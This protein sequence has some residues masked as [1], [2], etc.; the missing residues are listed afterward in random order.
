M[1]LCA[2][3]RSGALRCANTRTQAR[4]HALAGT[5]T[6]TFASKRCKQ[7]SA[8]ARTLV[9]VVDS[10]AQVSLDVVALC[11][12]CVCLCA[13]E[14]RLCVSKHTFASR[15][16]SPASAQVINLDPSA[17]RWLSHGL[18]RRRRRRRRP[19]KRASQRAIAGN[20]LMMMRPLCCVG[21]INNPTQ[22]RRRRRLGRCAREIIH[23]ACELPICER[24]TLWP[25][26]LVSAALL[27]ACVLDSTALDSASHH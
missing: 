3:A 7:T 21:R 1:V 14:Q 12:S 19:G 26:K 17:A 18:R 15:N 9:S 25:W 8:H 20:L 2:R 16:R 5:Q 10:L 13:C 24:P 27:C 22:R 23:S 11:V 6:G 4:T